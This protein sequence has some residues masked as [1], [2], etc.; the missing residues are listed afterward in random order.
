MSFIDRFLARQL[1]DPN[2][3]FG[4]I[5]LSALNIFNDRLIRATVKAL[6]LNQG[7][8]LLDIGFGGG[9]V[10]GL[11]ARRIGRG[12]MAGVEPSATAISKVERRYHALIAAGQLTLKPGTAEALPFEDSRFDKACTLNTFYFWPDPIAGLKEIK[13]VLKPGGRLVLSVYSEDALRSQS[14]TQHGYTIRSQAETQSLL[15]E[16]GFA[17]KEIVH[18]GRDKQDFDCFI[19]LKQG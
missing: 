7:E 13:R 12:K 11:A 10:F 5:V 19:A 14:I 4:G 17:V 16:A 6:D 3:T 9:K 15:E 18:Q 2:G 1:R 8:A